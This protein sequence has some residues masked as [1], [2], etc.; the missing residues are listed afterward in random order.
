MSVATAEPGL[1]EE[2]AVPDELP[3]GIAPRGFAFSAA[4]HL[5]L[6]R[7]EESGRVLDGQ[8]HPWSLLGRPA[9]RL[10]KPLLPVA[11]RAT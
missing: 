9:R 7:G 5:V 2:I 4:V 3:E 11:T 1:T 10:C 6:V 8:T